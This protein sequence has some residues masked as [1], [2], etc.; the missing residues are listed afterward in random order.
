M[1]L[2][3]YMVLT[4][5]WCVGNVIQYYEYYGKTGEFRNSPL[6]YVE[7]GKPIMWLAIFAERQFVCSGFG[8]SALYVRYD[9]IQM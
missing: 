5:Y 4:F 7:A 3:Y 8:T 6:L 1:T 2:G 9:D